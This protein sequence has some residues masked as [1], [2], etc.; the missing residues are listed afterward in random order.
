MACER[1][2]GSAYM[3]LR[4]AR[5]YDFV[6]RRRRE[7]YS[8]DG[9]KRAAIDGGRW[10]RGSDIKVGNKIILQAAE[11]RATGEERRARSFVN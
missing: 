2:N 11:V 6:E 3:D 1:I 8:F 7:V 9:W 5:E 4:Y 10:T